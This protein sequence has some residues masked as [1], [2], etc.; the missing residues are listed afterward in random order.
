M[1]KINQLSEEVIGTCIKI[2]R[3]LGPGLLESVY[4]D[5]LHFE[6]IR[7]GLEIKRQHPVPVYWQNQRMN[8]GFRADLIINNQLII[9]IKSVEQIASVH[10]KQLL[11]YLKITDL[12]LG[13]LINFNEALLKD[14][15]RRVANGL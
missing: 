11:T 5:I 15:I 3:E 1:K 8:I 6:L 10:Y 4:E 9:E 13:L 2:H 14:G 12:K 7:S